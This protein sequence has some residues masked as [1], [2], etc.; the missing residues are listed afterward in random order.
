[1]LP[2]AK[3]RCSCFL[4]FPADHVSKYEP[5]LEFISNGGHFGYMANAS[6][7]DAHGPQP[8]T[9]IYC[10]EAQLRARSGHSAGCGE[11]RQ[12]SRTGWVWGAQIG[13]KSKGERLAPGCIRPYTAEIGLRL[14]GPPLPKS[15]TEQ[16]P[17]VTSAWGELCGPGRGR[18]GC[19]PCGHDACSV[20]CRCCHP[21]GF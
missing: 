8:T 2:H 3:A 20:R 1:M 21:R 12:T 13:K 15:R 7:T 9:S 19:A 17:F 11:P 4:W 16:C 10:P 18:L 14:T 6:A 5:F